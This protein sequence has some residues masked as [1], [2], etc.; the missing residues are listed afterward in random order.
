MN[1][2]NIGISELA[3]YCCFLQ[4]L[5]SVF[6]FSFFLQYFYCYQIFSF[7]TLPVPFINITKLART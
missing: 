6:F 7:V 5:D 1:S 2:D 4:E 3:H